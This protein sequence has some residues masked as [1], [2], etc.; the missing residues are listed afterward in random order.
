VIPFPAEQLSHQ[1]LLV[2]FLLLEMSP[3]LLVELLV[4]LLVLCLLL[5]FLPSPL[6]VLELKQLDREALS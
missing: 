5:V 4:L 3:L 6:V 1:V 2:L